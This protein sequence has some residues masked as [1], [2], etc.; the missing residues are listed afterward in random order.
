MS[1]HRLR[2]RGAAP[3]AVTSRAVCLGLALA[4]LVC[5]A[6]GYNDWVLHNT[7]LVGNHFPYVAI[8][9]ILALALVVN[10]LLRRFSPAA[11]LSGG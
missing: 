8:A 9:A 11:A 6:T 7:L 1:A 5:L 10:P 3:S 2:Q 4:A